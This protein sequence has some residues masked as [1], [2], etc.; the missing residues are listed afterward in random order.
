MSKYKD[1]QRKVL[2]IKPGFVDTPMTQGL[3]LPQLLLATPDQ[4]AADILKAIQKRRD[5][6][7]TPWFWR[8][9]MLIIQHIPSAIFKRLSL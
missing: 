7:Y 9:I 4:V 1:E 6:L 5:T 8:Y 2:T 3:A